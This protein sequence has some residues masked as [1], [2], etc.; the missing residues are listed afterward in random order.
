MNPYSV[1]QKG[2]IR[3]VVML[4]IMILVLSYFGFD[5]KTFIAKPI[6]QDNLSYA[7]ELVQQGWELFKAFISKF[8]P[9]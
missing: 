2:F 9:I 5:L 8:I 3:L 6:V 7:W 1:H 4:V